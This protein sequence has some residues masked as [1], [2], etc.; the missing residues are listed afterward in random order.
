M[1]ELMY[2]DFI[3]D[4]IIYFRVMEDSLKHKNF[5]EEKIWGNEEL[6][7]V[8]IMFFYEKIKHMEQDFFLMIKKGTLEYKIQ[9]INEKIKL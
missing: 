5:I 4:T 8:C 9:Q 1:Q 3:P 6:Y 2:L 7:N